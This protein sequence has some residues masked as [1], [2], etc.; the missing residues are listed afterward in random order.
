MENLMKMKPLPRLI[1]IIAAVG[2]IFYGVKVAGEKGMLS[3][4]N[5]GQA[6]TSLGVQVTPEVFK[7]APTPVQ[8]PAP[9]MA[10]QPAPVEVVVV[11]SEQPG[12]NAGLSGLMNAGA[13]K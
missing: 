11:P 7:P 10:A 5:A 6:A 12:S 1:M 2:A 9:Q 4:D 3:F 8:E 13:K